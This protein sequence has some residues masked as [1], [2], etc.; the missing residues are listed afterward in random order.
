[1]KRRTFFG[2]AF[3]ALSAPAFGQLAKEQAQPAQ[4]TWLDIDD[5]ELDQESA[6]DVA[7][8]VK[9][10]LAECRDLCRPLLVHF[11]GGL[12]DR[13]SALTSASNLEPYYRLAG[14][15]PYFFVYNT[16]PFEPISKGDHERGLFAVPDI[17]SV[18]IARRIA[19]P[20]SLDQ[21]RQQIGSHGNVTDHEDTMRDG[22][23]PLSIVGY[24][25]SL[26]WAYMKQSI[27]DGLDMTSESPLAPGPWPHI[28]RDKYQPDLAGGCAFLKALHQ[29]LLARED[30]P[31][32]VILLGHS[33]GAIYV[34]ELLR[35]FYASCDERLR[36]QL[37]EVIFLAP[38]VSYADFARM[39]E[40]TGGSQVSRLRIFTM[41]DCYEKEDRVLGSVFGKHVPFAVNYYNR[42]L[43]YLI[44]GDF[45]SHPDEPLLGLDRFNAPLSQLYPTSPSDPTSC[46]GAIPTQYF[47][48]LIA[49]VRDKAF[50][51][52]GGID[53]V[54][55]RSKTC[56]TAPCGRRSSATDH[57]AFLYNRDTLE[58]LAYLIRERPPA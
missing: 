43:L 51:R 9:A 13:E 56:T 29:E 15:I 38:A 22:L 52:W 50:S 37:F 28:L 40:E 24:N 16:G 44:S 8:D 10:L 32:R 58:S 2:G 47:A 41:L 11:H 49:C 48:D 53:G 1:V 55:V 39:W 26:A 45:E 23:P 5:G 30:Q 17:R 4:G 25:G 14:A 19:V 46:D 33:A 6:A 35:K 54:F 7:G 57:S 18:S 20:S 27:L 42:S 12:V 36:K 21:C 34:T 31:V 3:A